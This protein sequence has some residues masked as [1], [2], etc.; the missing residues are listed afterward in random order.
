MHCRSHS[1]YAALES[2]SLLIQLV[3]GRMPM[4]A[5]HDWHHAQ[6]DENFGVIGVL[7]RL[8]GTSKRWREQITSATR[9]RRD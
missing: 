5:F 1:G 7:D 2:D 3:L 8:H 4:A 6:F 9:P